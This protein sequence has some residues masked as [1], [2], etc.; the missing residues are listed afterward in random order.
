MDRVSNLLRGIRVGHIDIERVPAVVNLCEGAEQQRVVVVHVV[1]PEV[2][3][4]VDA[5][6]TQEPGRAKV[7]Q[8]SEQ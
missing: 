4:A 6:P 5:V 3:S 1:A 2:V 7:V 8:R